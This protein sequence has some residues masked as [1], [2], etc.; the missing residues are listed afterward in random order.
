M[1]E[2]TSQGES[3]VRIRAAE[4]RDLADITRIQNTFLK[5]DA[6]EWTE[7]LHTIEERARWMQAQT[8]RGFPVL[9]AIDDTSGQTLGWAAYGDFRDT[10]R[11]PGYRLTVEHTIHVDHPAWGRG[12]GRRL[13][14]A[15]I[16]HA[17]GAGVHAMIGGITGENHAS[18]QF[19]A[20]LGFVEV[21]RLP[22]VGVKLGRWLDLVLVQKLLDD[23]VRPENA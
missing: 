15:L 2:T 3:P 18:L 8:Q 7:T 19:H 20:R 23:R 16:E 10:R 11:W 9:L 12:V 1:L 21:A 4:P 17:R 5:T 22:Q 13:M 14:H 6:I